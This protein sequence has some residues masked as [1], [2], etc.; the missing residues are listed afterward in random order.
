[1]GYNMTSDVYDCDFCG[2]E[3]PWDGSDDVHGEIWECEVCGH[4]FCSKCFIDRYG[5]DSFTRML[6]DFDKVLCPVCFG[7]QEVLDDT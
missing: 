1:M 2:V 4:T 6:Q 5:R 7:D 3:I